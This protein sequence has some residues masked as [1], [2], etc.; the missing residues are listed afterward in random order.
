[1]MVSDKRQIRVIIEY[2]NNFPDPQITWPKKEFERVSTS[3]WATNEILVFVLSHTDWT[4][5]KSV[6]C[7]K[8]KVS[9]YARR[10]IRYEEVSEIFDTAYEV[11][12]DISDILN[13][14]M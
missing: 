9:R 6:E 11:A 10:M 12:C 8:K 14:M 1:M 13:A 3:R 2:L 7:F 4:V 5:M